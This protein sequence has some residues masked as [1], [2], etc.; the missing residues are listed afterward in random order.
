M[1]KNILKNSTDLLFRKQTNILSAA[2]VIALTVLFSR[3][4]GLIKLRLLTDY[5]SVSDLGVFW[6]AFRLP[7]TIFD[8]IVMGALTAAFIPVFTQY[9]SKERYKEANA[10]ASTILNVSTIIFIVLSTLLFVF[11]SQLVNL[12]APGLTNAE[13]EL[14]ANFTRIMLIGQALPLVLGNF[15]TGILQS[16]KRFLIPALAPIAY[17]IGIILSIF[18]LTP[19]MGLYAA[20]WGTVIGAFLFLLIQIPLVLHLRYRY[21]P[22]LDFKDPGVKEI[23]RLILPRT[24]GLAVVQLN[25]SVNLII[26]SIIST[27]AIAV[28]N[29]AQQLEQ[30]PISIFA[31]TISQAALPTLAEEQDQGDKLAAFKKTFLTSLHQIMFLVLPAAAILIVLRIPVVRLI[32]GASKFDWLA[33]VDTGRTLAFLGLGILAEAITYLLVRGFFALHDSKTPVILSAIAVTFNIVLSL[34]FVPVLNLPI[35]GLGLSAAIADTIYAACL[36]FFLNR[37]VGGFNFNDLFVPAIKMLLAAVLTGIA[38]YIPMKL[39]DQLIFDTTRTLPLLALTGVATATGLSVYVF[40]TW[41]L[42]IEELNSF[43]ALFRRAK[44]ILFAAEETVSEVVSTTVTNEPIA[45]S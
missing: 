6:A 21:V 44:K 42:Q 16:Y 35:W 37:R 9:I 30:L 3:F 5:F 31:A 20:V 36:L 28:F 45:H 38:L 43:I 25:Y 32:Y 7:N 41:A 13:A 14:A 4:L 22:V 15:L 8:I 33:T 17:N 12:L 40:F 34:V 19:Y 39:L 2:T 11:S 18:F 1:V 26:S 27:R 29:F 10:I 23:G 24:L